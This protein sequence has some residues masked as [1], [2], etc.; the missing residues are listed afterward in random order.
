MIKFITRTHEKNQIFIIHCLNKPNHSIHFWPEFHKELQKQRERE[1]ACYTI[2]VH[3]IIHDLLSISEVCKRYELEAFNFNVR[4][5]IVYM[6][7]EKDR[8]QYQEAIWGLRHQAKQ[9]APM[10]YL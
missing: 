7:M 2:H 4:R 9:E 8:Y 1:M 6:D 5:V 3:L 10:L